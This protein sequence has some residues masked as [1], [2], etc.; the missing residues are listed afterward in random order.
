MK[1]Y[2]IILLIIFISSVYNVFSNNEKANNQNELSISLYDAITLSLKNNLDYN[3]EKLKLDDK[4]W[5]MYASGNILLPSVNSGFTFYRYLN[6]KY[7]DFAY[8][9]DFNLYLKINYSLN[10]SLFFSFYENIINYKMQKINLDSSK[11]LL[12]RNVK[13]KYYKILIDKKNLDILNTELNNAKQLYEQTKIIYE[14]GLSSEY[15]LISSK[16]KYENAKPVYLLKKKDY[17]K[18][19]ADFKL[20]IGIIDERQITLVDDL[21]FKEYKIS[22]ED[23]IKNID[24]RFD[25]QMLN[26]SSELLINTNKKNISLLMPN[27]FFTFTSDPTFKK[28]PFRNDW[29]GNYDYMNN[30]WKN[31]E[32]KISFGVDFP[33]SYWIPFSKEQMKIMTSTNQLYQKKNEIMLSKKSA[34][35][36]IVSLIESIEESKENLNSLKENIILAQKS[37]DIAIEGYKSG[38][39]N[40]LDIQNSESDLIKANNNYLSE[41]L[42]YISSIIDL[43][44][45]TNT[46]FQDK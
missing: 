11:N 21:E 44:Y 16:V 38:T 5:L 25:I 3:N 27:I 23:I 40:F 9:W 30:N 36:E 41:E 35:I 12:I 26:M 6:N 19:I 14:S 37:Y 32:G 7:E 43:E 2:K 46:N 13:K 45:A 29:F 1:I 18:E 39:K 20:M 22:K 15:N 34:I 42:N 10:V 31:N 17:N 4:R 8:G 24:N 33:L 28:D